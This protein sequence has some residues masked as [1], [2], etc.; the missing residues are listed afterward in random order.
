MGF[1]R[2]VKDFLNLYLFSRLSVRLGF[3]VRDPVKLKVQHGPVEFQI[4]HDVIRRCYED[5]SHIHGGNN[6]SDHDV[7]EWLLGYGAQSLGYLTSEAFK[8]GA[9]YGYAV[10]QRPLEEIDY[11]HQQEKYF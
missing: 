1:S 3:V 4:T 8:A 2:L 11:A 7:F 5:L 10:G 9:N 6:F